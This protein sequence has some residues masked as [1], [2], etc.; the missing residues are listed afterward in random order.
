MNPAVNYGD[1]RRYIHKLAFKVLRRAHAAGAASLQLEDVVSELTVA[2]CIARDRYDP[3]TGVPFIAYFARGAF[4]HVN[5][6]IQSEITGS[7][8]LAL[9]SSGSEE[10]ENPLHETIPEDAPS[11]L[12]LVMSGQIREIA[13]R[14]LSEEAWRFLT[15]LESP[16]AELVEEIRRIRARGE[17]ARERGIN[18]VTPTG[19]V[20]SLVFD[21]MG[22]DRSRRSKILK[23][24]R[25]VSGEISQL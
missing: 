13:R 8:A 25:I 11:P 14:R 4:N 15:L 7:H 17:Y 19:V 16:P 23:E 6:W 12:D 3:E 9:D 24:I 5:R 18:T 2:W 22:F 21:L 20:A 10:I 1:C